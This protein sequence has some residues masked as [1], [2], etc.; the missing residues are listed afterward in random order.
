MSCGKKVIPLVFFT[1]NVTAVMM[2][3]TWKIYT[4]VGSYKAIFPQRLHHFQ[5]TFANHE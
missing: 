3:F 4:P 2:K 1:G 5:H